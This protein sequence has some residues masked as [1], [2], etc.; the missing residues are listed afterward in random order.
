MGDSFTKS[1]FYEDLE[2]VHALGSMLSS[3]DYTNSFSRAENNAISI[4]D[5]VNKGR[6]APTTMKTDVEGVDLDDLVVL[7]TY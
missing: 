2:N 6:P 3:L 5:F 4:D 1:E 7:K